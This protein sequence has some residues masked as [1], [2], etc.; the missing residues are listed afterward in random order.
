MRVGAGSLVVP[1]RI[2][3]DGADGVVSVGS[4][5]FVG[6]SHFVC[7]QAITIGDDVL[8]SWNATIVD[9][10]SH[11]IDWTKRS[12]DVTD[13]MQGM[14][15]WDHVKVAPVTIGNKCWIGFGA[16]ILK[17]V[18]I[19]EGAVVGA[20][21]VV[22]RDVAPFTVVAGNPARV[23]RSLVPADANPDGRSRD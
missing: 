16:T 8:I 3:F 9:H 14:K 19:G 1:R 21:A 20:C 13:W 5:T 7:R 12:G 6:A 22:T 15:R 11:S 4:R 23:V 18:T 2:D 17:G 10:D